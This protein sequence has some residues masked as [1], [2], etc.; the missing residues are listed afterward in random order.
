MGRRISVGERLAIDRLTEPWT[1]ANGESNGVDALFTGAGE[2]MDD[3]AS[4]DCIVVAITVAGYNEAHRIAERLVDCRKA[5]SVNVVPKIRTLSR[6][7]ARVEDLEESFVLARTTAGL[8]DDVLALVGELAEGAV[9][10]TI[11]LPILKARS[12][13]V[14]QIREETGVGP[15]L[16]VQVGEYQGLARLKNTGPASALLCG[17]PV[18][19]RVRLWGGEVFFPIQLD[20]EPSDLR[21]EVELGDICYWSAARSLCIFLGATPLS[22]A[23]RI[24]PLTPV[25]VLGRVSD[26]EA[27][28]SRI[29]A[30][31]QITLR[32]VGGEGLPIGREAGEQQ[33]ER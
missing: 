9:A 25:E 28:M 5:A 30:G 21:R 23:G 12:E 32:A 18:T 13:H 2:G 16:V 26:P 11:G 15:E 24:K 8:F 6:H 22:R 17:L 20:I 33:Q 31:M 19:S 10:E 14:S 4:Q 7:G 3:L 27:L 29:E 1:G